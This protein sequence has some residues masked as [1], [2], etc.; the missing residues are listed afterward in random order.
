L[1]PDYVEAY[2]NYLLAVQYLPNYS[3]EQLLADHMAFAERFEMPLRQQWQLAAKPERV[4]RRLKVGFVSGDL[5]NHPVGFF[6]E[7]VLRHIDRQLI[8]V[9]LYSSNDAADVLTERLRALGF[10]WTALTAMSDADAA[11]RIRADKIDILVDLAGH[12]GYHRLLV[13]ARKPAPLQVAWLGYWATTGLRSI[14][15]ILC[16][17]YC[18]PADEARFFVEQPWYLPNTRLCFTAPPDNIAV[19][20][21]PALQSGQITFGCFNNLAKMTDAIVALWARILHGIT[22]ARLLLKSAAL[23]DSV[24]RQTVLARFAAQGI[25]AERLQLE[26]F[27]ARA[28]YFSSYQRVDIALDPFPFTGGTTSIEGIWMGVPMITRRGDRMVAHQGESILHNLGLPEWIASDDDAYVRLAIMHAA[29]LAALAELRMQLRQRLLASPLC[30][31]PQFALNLVSALQQMW[32][33]N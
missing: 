32:R 17:R 24:M 18:V 5:H 6:L 14:D 22:N 2:S 29:D 4:Q 8:D 19:L 10:T 21:L 15:Y 9:T 27:S 20:P 31:A 12:T 25:G 11:E 33:S 30:N 1:K 23:G 13:F 26:S 28:D 3:R 7:G 16:D